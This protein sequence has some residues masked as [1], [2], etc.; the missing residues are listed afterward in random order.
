[1]QLSIPRTRPMTNR[2]WRRRWGR[3]AALA[4]ALFLLKGLGW[5]AAA[6]LAWRAIA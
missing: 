5:L 3:F 6:W 4:A 1:M 2:G